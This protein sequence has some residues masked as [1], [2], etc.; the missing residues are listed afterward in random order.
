VPFIIRW[1]GQVPAGRVDTESVVSFI[2]WLP[3]LSAIAGVK[4]LPEQLDGEDISAI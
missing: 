3:T 1:P 2:D 4:T